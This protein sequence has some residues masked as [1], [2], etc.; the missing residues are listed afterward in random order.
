[1]EIELFDESAEY[2]DKVIKMDD[3]SVGKRVMQRIGI[4]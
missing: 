3:S 1:M 2:F 4:C